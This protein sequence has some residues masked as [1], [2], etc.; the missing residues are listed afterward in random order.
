MQSDELHALRGMQ[1][2]LHSLRFLRSLRFYL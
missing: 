2:V 1:A